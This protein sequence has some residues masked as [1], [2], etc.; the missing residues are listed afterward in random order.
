MANIVFRLSTKADKITGK[1]EILARFYHGKK[2]I[3]RA[4]TNLF[5]QPEYW[6]EKLQTVKIPNTRFNTPEKL[7]LIKDLSEIKSELD[8]I[9]KD[10]LDAFIAEGGSKVERPIGWLEDFLA[11]RRKAQEK[12]KRKETKQ[13]KVKPTETRISK[14]VSNQRQESF[15][16][17]FDYFI[18][19]QKVSVSRI[20]RLYVVK[21]ALLRYALYNREEVSF[22]TFSGDLI[23][24]FAEFLE[25]E[26]SF[27]GVDDEGKDYILDPL[28]RK[29]YDSVP[30][31]RYPKERGQNTLI[32]MLSCLRTF[33]RWATQRGY[34]LRN[35]FVDYTIGTAVYGT[36]FYLTKEERNQLYQAK[37]PNNP[38]LEVQRDIFVFQC[39]IGCRVSD[40]KKMTKTSVIK[41]AIEY[42]PRKTKNG[43]PVTVRVPLSPTAQE[44]L[45]RYKDIPGDKLLPFICDQDY[46][47]DIKKM[48][49][50]AGID[51]MV[52]TLN[53]LTREEEKHPIWEVA[54]SHMARRVL[55]G[56][57][58]KEIKD[59]NL[60][61]KISGHVENST[62]FNRYRGIDDDLAKETILKLE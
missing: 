53:S 15:F 27:V 32:G 62:A 10:V 59:P 12:E 49:R 54:S 43:H 14:N 18:S 5:L 34:M 25:I 19:I 28:Y 31:C 61:A 29:V 1:V 40:L 16:E 47:R 57:L 41:G 51:R 13:K 46:N 24:D 48:I 7:Q 20:R 44:I 52:T 55:I 37:F 35:P 11:N 21:R 3:F 42:I 9:S 22:E 45:D 26:H 23:R 30:E 33:L 36:P 6:N 56:N 17:T 2:N 50:L 4:K 38:G 8:S 58:Y 60:I 39:F